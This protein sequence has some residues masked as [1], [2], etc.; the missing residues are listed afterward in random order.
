[1]SIP[2][3]IT[4]ITASYAVGIGKYVFVLKDGQYKFK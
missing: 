3:P 1:M 4:I 2:I